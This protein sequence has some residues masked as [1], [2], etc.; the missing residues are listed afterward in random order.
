[1]VHREP[2]GRNRRSE[3]SRAHS[4]R[5]HGNHAP[6]HKWRQMRADHVRVH[7]FQYLCNVIFY[8]LYFCLWGLCDFNLIFKIVHKNPAGTKHLL[9]MTYMISWNVGIQKC[10]LSV[11]ICSIVNELPSIILILYQL[12]FIY[13]YDC[14][15]VN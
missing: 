3:A 2:R 8:C 11:L 4:P 7:I 9:M 5:L 1:M 6:S 15:I 14:C 13:Y 12:L 10:Y